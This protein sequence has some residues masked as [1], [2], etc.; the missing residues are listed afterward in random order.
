MGLHRWV[1]LTIRHQPAMFGGYRPC[2]RGDIEF[3]ICHVTSRDHV[4]RESS[5]IMGEFPSLLVTTLPSLVATGLAEEIFCFNLSQDLMWP[6]GQRV[7]WQYGWVFL[8]ISHHL[9]K[10]E[11]L[12]L[13]PYL[14][15]PKISCY[16]Y[17][18]Y[19]LLILSSFWYSIQ[20]CCFVE[21]VVPRFSSK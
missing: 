13:D 21:A 4:I 3:S 11:I 5:D 14:Q 17:Y 12:S 15:Q 19:Y 16:Y 6:P 7:L 18:K 1:P 9:T 20:K 10:V 2:Q 8:S